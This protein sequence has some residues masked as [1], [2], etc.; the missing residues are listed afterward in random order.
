MST[1]Q[2]DK[3]NILFPS[4]RG[5]LTEGITYNPSNNTLLWVDIIQAQ[6]HRIRLDDEEDYGKHHEVISLDDPKESAGALFL[7]KD[8]DIVLIS[9]K[10]GVC[11]GAFSTGK[12]EYI[13]KYDHNAEEQKRLRSNDGIVDP[14]G[15]LWIGVMT[16]FPEGGVQPEG[17]LYRVDCGDLSVKTMV[18]DTYI[19]NGLAF[20]QDGKHLY[21]TDSLTFTLWKFDY[22]H[23]SATLSN[24]QACLDYRTLFPD[25]ESPEP[26]G[27]AMTRGGD[28]YQ[29]VFSTSQVVQ[30][31][32]D[33]KMHARFKVP[34]A[35]VSCVC[36][37]GKDDNELFITTGHL[38]LDDPSADIDAND[39]S[40]DLGG[41]LFRLKLNEK[42]GGAPKNVWGGS[43]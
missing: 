35:R 42:L 34:A 29:A 7:T 13:L 8:S 17:R 25:V 30:V 3:S 32:T 28:I 43:I 5:R 37:G 38:K 14:W 20:D 33:G 36:V 9:T 39:K 18:T 19:S 1:Y 6:V 23:E 26:D 21:W 16:D 27:L 24:R 41:F 11:K 31:S 22:D 15:H 4:Y 2:L 10:Y 12:A 40:G